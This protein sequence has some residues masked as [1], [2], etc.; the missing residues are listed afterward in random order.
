MEDSLIFDSC[1]KVSSSR[2]KHI[3]EAYIC[4]NLNCTNGDQ[5]FSVIGA[6]TN[7]VLGYFGLRDIIRTINEQTKENVNMLM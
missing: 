4:F 3:R 7:Q 5:Q 6:L 2:G 1:S